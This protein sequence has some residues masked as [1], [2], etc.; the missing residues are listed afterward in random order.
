[1]LQSSSVH[2]V[3]DLSARRRAISVPESA[4][5]YAFWW[6]A[7]REQLMNANRHIVLQGPG[8]ERVD[9]HY[10]DWWPADAPYPCL[11][12]GKTTNL[13]RRFGQHLLRGTRHRAHRS[14]SDNLKAKPK[15]TA[16][17]LRFGMEHI[18]PNHALP[19]QLIDECV[20]FSWYDGYADNAVAE[21][22]FNEDR[23][24]G[25]MR[26]WFNIDSER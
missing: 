14:L 20:G 9:V 5:V 7:P 17:Q 2:S 15:T 13:K 22:F 1:M 8:G 21:R 16:C 18:F 24:V 6:T 26:P 11:Y 10:R 12:V 23:L 25:Y 3:A 19:L 4:G